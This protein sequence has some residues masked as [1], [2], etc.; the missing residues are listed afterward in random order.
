MNIPEKK[1]FASDNNSGIHHLLLKAITDAN[2]G[3]AAAYG[4][5]A[6]TVAVKNIFKETFGENAE[7]YFV[8]NGT[9]ANVLGISALTKSFNAV[10]CTG[11]AHIHVDECGAPEKFSNCKL[12]PLKTTD[13]KLSAEMIPDQLQ[14]TGFEHH[15]QPVVVSISQQIGRAHV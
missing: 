13:G 9:G 8:L 12:I 15:V 1:G 3:H 5:D 6:Y 7:V 14:G 2:S 4:D 10:I 11:T